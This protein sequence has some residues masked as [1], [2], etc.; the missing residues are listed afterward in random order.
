M[1]VTI[2]ISAGVQVLPTGRSRDR[3][4]RGL[5]VIECCCGGYRGPTSRPRK[6]RGRTDAPRECGKTKLFE[7]V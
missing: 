2:A 1:A 7:K 3:V 5:A 6:K 4:V